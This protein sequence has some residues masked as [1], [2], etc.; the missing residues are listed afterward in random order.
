MSDSEINV[1]LRRELEDS[2][3][4]Q[5]ADHIAECEICREKLARQKDALP[6]QTS[7]EQDLHKLADHITEEELQQYVTGKLDLARIRAIDGHLQR[8]SQ[9][10]AEVGDL[11]NFVTSLPVATP[12]ARTPYAFWRA[13]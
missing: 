8:C 12:Q 13:G 3:L 9:C 4:L 5:L 2:R 7:I 11:R 1:F 6:A 10:A